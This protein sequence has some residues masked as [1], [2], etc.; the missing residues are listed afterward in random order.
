MKRAEVTAPSLSLKY[1]VGI[2]ISKDNFAVCFCVINQHQ[3]VKILGTRTF[4]NNYAGFEKLDYWI[5]NKKKHPIDLRIVMEATGV[6]YENVAWYLHGLEYY[7]SVVLPN[8]SKKYLEGI[9]LISKNDKVDAKG[10][11][12]MGAEQNLALWC[13]PEEN[14]LTLRDLTRQRQMIQESKTAFNN[15]KQAF[16]CAKERHPMVIKNLNEILETLERQLE[17]LDKTLLKLIQEDQVLKEKIDKITLIKGVAWLTVVTVLAE[18]GGFNMIRNQSQLVSYAGYDVIENQSGKHFGK[19]HISKKG[20]ARIRRIMHMPAFNVVKYEE[21]VFKALYERV[22]DRSK[23]KMKAYV[24]VQRK[25][26][27]L[28]YSLWKN[29]QDYK[30]NIIIKK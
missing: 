14:F 24:A 28:I 10:L 11:A 26:L 5:K 30:P 12:R 20:N 3:V 2:D 6:Y 1:S 21:P 19:T 16:L 18:T 27:V 17:E 8:R 15:Q 29:E 13:P 7:L 4:R 25:L 22:F 9:G 23:I